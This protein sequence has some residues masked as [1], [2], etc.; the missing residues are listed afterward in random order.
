MKVSIDNMAQ[1][2]LKELQNYSEEVTEEVKKEVK[3]VAK[4]CVD[5]IKSN[6]PK[7]SGKYA[8]GWGVTVNYESDKDIRV[9]V[10]NKTSY[11]LTHL[12][13]NGHAKVNG[14]RVPGFPHIAH[15]EANAIKKLPDNVEARIRG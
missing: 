6:S 9:T 13:E 4:E 12:L 5:E 7:D 1:A 3:A 2:V 11:R 15:A 10:H 14:G 8:A